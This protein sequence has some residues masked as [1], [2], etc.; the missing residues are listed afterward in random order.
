MLARIIV[1]TILVGLFIG[2]WVL[3]LPS[4]LRMFD[5]G[6]REVRFVLPA[7]FH[8]AFIVVQDERG[9]DLQ[10]VDGIL[11]VTVH[12]TRIARVRTLE[13][14]A[15]MHKESWTTID[16]RSIFHDANIGATDN[17]NALR[18]IGLQSCGDAKDRLK[19]F[20]GTMHD[21]EAFDFCSID[22]R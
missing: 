22:V 15:E 12:P 1:G 13:P 10:E 18:S 19:Y 9:D 5:L 6:P 17:E 7:S 14:F 8:G 4:P 20:M 2:V 3:F 11:V 21:A 16:N